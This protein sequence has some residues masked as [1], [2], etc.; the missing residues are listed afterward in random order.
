VSS[1]LN[2]FLWFSCDKARLTFSDS[3]SFNLH[4][5]FYLKGV[6]ARS[7]GWKFSL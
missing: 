3:C 7:A 1:D 6:K 2:D 5:L 4:Q